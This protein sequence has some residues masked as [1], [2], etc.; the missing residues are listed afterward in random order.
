MK[1]LCLLYPNILWEWIL[2]LAGEHFPLLSIVKP[3]FVDEVLMEATARN[4]KFN[5]IKVKVC[6][7]IGMFEQALCEV[8]ASLVPDCIWGM[9]IVFD[10]RL[11]P[12]PSIIKEGHVNLSFKQY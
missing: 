4:V 1:W 12:L 3:R 2:C 6:M 8:I 5:G 10:R 9:Y 11:F 7:R